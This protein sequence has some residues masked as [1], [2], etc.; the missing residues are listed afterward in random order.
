MAEISYITQPDGQSTS[1]A[2]S[3]V[4]LKLAVN[5]MDIAAAYMTSSGVRD[6]LVVMNQ[7]S[8]AKD[9]NVKKRWITSF[10]YCRTDPLA[11]EAIHALPSSSVR[12]YG[13]DACL[14]N[15]GVPNV[16]FHP[17]SFLFRAAHQYC[18]LAGS[19]N[20]SRSGLSRGI[21]MGL[22][23]SVNKACGAEVQSA[24]SAVDAL[25]QSFELRWQDAMPL[26]I[27]LLAQ[28]R[29]LYEKADRLKNAV[30]T[31]DDTASSYKS[32]GSLSNDSLKKLRICR[33]LWIEAGNITKNRG[34]GLP[35]N[36]LMMKR[37]SRVFFGFEP[38]QVPKNTLIGQVNISIYQDRSD[39]YPLTY[40]DNS[41]D[42]LVLP[43]PGAGGPEHYDGKTLFFE[44]LDVNRF[45]LSVGTSSNKA[46]WLR[47]S[48]LID[49]AFKMSSGRQ[50]GV[51]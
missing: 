37:L 16:P 8:V 24:I 3:Q 50:W 44:Q 39:W 51:F 18:A 47:R 32:R 13:A 19:G 14:A 17:K 6:L 2:I 26:N 49:G 34:P 4:L 28:Y 36:Q 22:V 20:I 12:I 38:T 21:E 10:D 41:M 45:Q 9:K 35:G 31:E 15:N 11:L 5:Q 48:N 23:V 25:R 40:S 1:A 29:D 27:R 7:H 30:P 33:R 42:K 43:I 46:A